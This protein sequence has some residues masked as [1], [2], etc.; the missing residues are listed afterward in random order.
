MSR[1]RLSFN[2]SEKLQQ[3]H[4]DVDRLTIDTDDDIISWQAIANAFPNVTTIKIC[5][6]A[7]VGDK[8]GIDGDFF[9]SFPALECLTIDESV[10]TD[11][12][13]V[14]PNHLSQLSEL[15]IGRSSSADLSVLGGLPKLTLLILTTANKTTR[16]HAQ[17]TSGLKQVE[18]KL[19]RYC[20]ELDVDFRAA[21]LIDL[22]IDQYDV[23]RDEEADAVMIKTLN[24]PSCLSTLHIGIKTESALPQDMFNNVQQLKRFCLGQK[25][26]TITESLFGNLS[27]V[28]DCR[29]ILIDIDNPLPASL[30]SN[31][32]EIESLELK[33]NNTQ[34]EQDFFA[35]NTPIEKLD[36]RCDNVDVTPLLNTSLPKLKTAKLDWHHEQPPMW[37]ANSPELT[38]LNLHYAGDLS[39]LPV[40]PNLTLC[41]LHYVNGAQLPECIRHNSNLETLAL[42]T[43]AFPSLGNLT[44]MTGLKKINIH[45]KGCSEDQLPNID[46]IV[47]VPA[48]EHVGLDIHPTSIDPVWLQL[49][50]QVEIEFYNEHLTTELALLRSTNLPFEQCLECANILVSIKKPAELPAMPAEFHIALMAAKY[51]RFKAQNKTWLRQ[52]AEQS[53]QQ[54]PL[55]KDS[56]IFISGRSAFKAA[57]LKAKSAELGFTLSKNL[58]NN[59]THM[60]LGSAPK[61]I[62]LLDLELHLL[63]DDSSLQRY[64][65]TEVPKFLQQENSVAMGD[66]VLAMLASPD[67]AT[68]QVA[69]QMLAQGGVTEA[70]RLPL[71]FILKTTTDNKLRKQIKELLAGM[72][73]GLFQLAVNDRILFNACQGLDKYGNLIGQGFMVDKL[74]KQKK[75]W[76]DLLCNQFAKLY[77]DRT[78]EGLIYLMMQKETSAEQLDAFRALI[79]GECLN[80]RRGAAFEQMLAQFDE[81]SIAH[82]R[83]HINSSTSVN[84]DG[85][86][87][88]A[89]TYLPAELAENHGISALDLGHCLLDALPKGIEHYRHIRRLSLS[90]NA[91]AKLPNDFAL[92][93]E[94]EELSLSHNHFT[95]F[96]EVLLELKNL[97]RLDLRCARKP[98]A[99]DDYISTY[100]Y[101]GGT[102]REG[103]YRPIRAPQSFRD[104]LPNCEILEDL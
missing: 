26:G 46:S 40:L 16:F 103:V 102:S 45:P 52:I 35:Q 31:L 93:S 44:A 10:D 18:L 6:L 56:V 17:A 51:N 64:F 95:A 66:T 83:R 75:K 78:G 20:N 80:W 67:E 74:K 79:D 30:L 62:E 50:P 81:Q 13:D 14:E 86:L 2:T 73:D 70:M 58:D 87:G 76:G 65:S 85:L 97:K 63:I 5:E 7:K 90:D 25:G 4:P 92:F 42:F 12:T 11:F 23:Y 9:A 15:V 60:L 89:K 38:T 88:Q 53:E 24:L 49:A 22:N 55:A 43:C 59:V 98:V 82:Y 21:S 57:E 99:S 33:L 37:L 54:K 100:T 96:P 77:F 47:D 101:Q 91:L 1:S 68:H 94:L 3:I 34:L 48:L 32:T 84:Y 19:F 104:A 36:L 27:H 72:G 28:S 8:R 41:V 69:V 61:S 39:A 71:F 29:L